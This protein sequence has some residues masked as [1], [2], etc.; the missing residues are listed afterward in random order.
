MAGVSDG[1]VVVWAGISGVACAR[2]LREAGV[3]LRVLDRGERIG[4]R[5][6][7]RTEQVDGGDHPVDVGAQYFTVSDQRFAAVVEGWRS[8][9]LAR[10]WTDTF[11]LAGPDGLLGTTTGPVRW[12]SP[13]G[14]RALVEDLAAELDVV[15]PAEAGEVAVHPGE[16]PTLDGR[17]AAAVVLAM[18]DPLARALLPAR[19]A[20]EL[21]L[22]EAGTWSPTICVWAGWPERWWREIDAA[23]VRDSAVLTWIADDGR[24]RGD[25]AAVLVGHVAAVTAAGRLDDPDSAAG[26]VLDELGRILAPGAAVPPPDWVRC[27]PWAL[28]SALHLHERPFGLHEAGIGVCGDAWGPRSRVEQAW[29]SGHLLGEELVRTL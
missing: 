24:R 21:E 13:H 12:T 25:L 10:P 22:G 15:H 4:G 2:V 17:A 29:L 16:R 1:V 11:H 7:V 28:A 5:M 6:A 8:R 9:G 26:P 3:P 18:P 14:L 27:H 19:V 20:D 23:F